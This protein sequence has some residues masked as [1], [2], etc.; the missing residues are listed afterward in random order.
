MKSLMQAMGKM[1]SDLASKDDQGTRRDGISVRFEYCEEVV[2]RFAWCKSGN[3]DAKFTNNVAIPSPSH[4]GS[5]HVEVPFAQFATPAED[6]LFATGVEEHELDDHEQPI[7][8]LVYN[9]LLA[10]PP[11]V[12]GTCMSRIVFVGGGSKIPGIRQ[13]VMQDVA[14]LVSEHG[15]TSVRGRAVKEQRKRL[16]ELSI[17]RQMQKASLTPNGDSSDP[18][19]LPEEASSPTDTK[20][21]GVKTEEELDFVEQKLRRIQI[22]ESKPS[23]QGQFRQIESLGAWAGASLVT[24]LK[25]RGLVEIEREKFLQHG[26]ASASRDLDNTHHVPDRRSGLGARSSGAGDRSSWTLGGWGI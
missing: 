8:V 11:D 12:R 22:R 10:L 20:E 3:K 19:T 14:A 16:Q 9:T 24:S 2:N 13:R 17:N 6:A 1:L 7:H 23:V 4:P 18:A 25:I 15:W 5:T 26:L 21:N